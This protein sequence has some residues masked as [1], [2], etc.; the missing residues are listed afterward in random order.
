MRCYCGLGP[1]GYQGD[2]RIVR[3]DCRK[4]LYG[5]A[6]VPRIKISG[7][8]LERNTDPFLTRMMISAGR[9]EHSST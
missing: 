1:L 4:F 5:V 8:C 9:L 2:V 7:N 6:R 3:S